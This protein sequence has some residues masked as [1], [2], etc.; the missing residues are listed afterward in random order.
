M[1][2]VLKAHAFI[3]MVTLRAGT[4]VPSL[5]APTGH[6]LVAGVGVAQIHHGLEKEG[7]EV[8]RRENGREQVGER[9]TGSGTG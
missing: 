9:E 6:P 2:G 7:G 1:A 3:A 4:Q 8:R 5:G